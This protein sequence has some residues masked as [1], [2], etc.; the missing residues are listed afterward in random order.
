VYVSAPTQEFKCGVGVPQAVERSVLSILILQQ[1]RIPHQ[2]PECAVQTG[3]L[4][5]VTEPE[6]LVR[7]SFSECRFKRHTVD[8][9]L[10]CV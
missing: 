3:R 9:P 10:P 8:V 6:Q 2:T 5:A 1:A 7:H 4:V